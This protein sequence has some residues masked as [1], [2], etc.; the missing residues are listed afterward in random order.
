MYKSPK[1]SYLQLD[2]I[3][4]CDLSNA[5]ILAYNI[6][7]SPSLEIWSTHPWQIATGW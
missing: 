6:E 5:K 4:L 2:V 7:Y 3:I 1:I